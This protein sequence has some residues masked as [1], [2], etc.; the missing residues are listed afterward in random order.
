VRLVVPSSHLARWSA[1]CT[2][3]RALLR[4]ICHRACAWTSTGFSARQT[5]NS[6]TSGISASN[7]LIASELSLGPTGRAGANGTPR[8]K[9]H[10][11][12]TVRR[13]HQR[14][15]LSNNRTYRLLF[16]A[17]A[18]TTALPPSD[19][20]NPVARPTFNVVALPCDVVDYLA[21]I[22]P[23]QSLLGWQDD[24]APAG[25]A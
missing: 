2:L 22:C 10:I 11:D 8:S 5:C 3:S 13:C 18:M 23:S 9:P 12:L 14:R 6:G 15:Y 4:R 25:Q 19:S 1:A 20:L 16:R 24:T 21:V 17:E 7:S